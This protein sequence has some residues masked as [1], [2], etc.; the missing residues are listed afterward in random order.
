MIYNYFLQSFD[1]IF[2][3]FC[4]CYEKCV[5]SNQLQK[6]IFQIILSLYAP[7]TPINVAWPEIPTGFCLYGALFVYFRFWLRQCKSWGNI[8][9][10]A[11]QVS[12]LWPGCLHIKE[13]L[14]NFIVIFQLSVFAHHRTKLTIFGGWL[15]IHDF[16]S[17]AFTLGKSNPVIDRWSERLWWWKMFWS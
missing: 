4:R 9:S 11:I 10:Q 7:K 8:W 14:E 5:L 13:V 15:P 6:S 3:Y 2:Y 17:V 1:A 16:S 12:G